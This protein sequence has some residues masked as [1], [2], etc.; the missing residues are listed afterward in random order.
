MSYFK[1]LLVSAA[2][3]ALFLCVFAGFAYAEENKTGVITG[4]VLNVREAPNTS[5]RILIQLEKGTQVAVLK[6][7]DGWTNIKY[8][9]VTG[10]V[11]SEYIAVKDVTVG[12]GTI[13]GSVV[14]V[15]SQPSTSADVIRTLVE[16][17]KIN[18]IGRSNDWYKVK[19]S[20]AAIG[21]I[22][23]DLISVKDSSVSRGDE[24]QVSPEEIAAASQPKEASSKG[25]EIVEYAKKFLG[26]RYVWGGNSPKEGFDCSGFVKYAYAHFDIDLNRVA[27]D[28]AK[29]GTKISKSD[30]KPGDLVFFD[31]NGGHNYINHVGIYIGGGK[32]IHASSSRSVHR[33][34]IT[35]L[36]S[37]FY[38]GAYMTGRRIVK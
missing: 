11:S 3:A 22:Y 35:D 4:T 1:K 37:G 33:V 34:T 18:V 17:T 24:E 8:N 19:T 12:T 13:T 2:V 31:T 36:N 25:E 38:S 5:A 28:Q 15:R 6:Q 27:A 16:G 23:K 9:N 30:L 20:D 10:W 26:V 29:Q 14:N 32:F 21:W 7:S